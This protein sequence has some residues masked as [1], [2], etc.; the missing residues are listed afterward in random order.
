VFKIKVFNALSI[1][2]WPFIIYLAQNGPSK[3][4]PKLKMKTSLEVLNTL[5]TRTNKRRALPL[6]EV[7]LD[8]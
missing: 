8:G 7:E 4:N 3:R 6:Q 5:V 2:I 1:A